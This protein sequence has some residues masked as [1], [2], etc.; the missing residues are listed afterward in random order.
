M[1]DQVNIEWEYSGKKDI[2]NGTGAYKEERFLGYLGSLI[3]PTLLIGLILT[4]KL[5]W[6]FVQIA[7]GL[8]LGFDIGGGMISNSLNSVKRFYH[9]PSKPSEGKSGKLVKNELIFSAIH[10]HPF[11]VGMVFHNYDWRYGLYWYVIFMASVLIV[12]NA[13]LYLKRPV[14]ML[15]VMVSILVNAYLITP[16]YG[17]QWF[18]PLLFLKIVYGHLV[19]EEPYRK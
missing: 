12:Y 2:I 10:L 16:V 3:I 4:D 9:S 11:V 1:K 18:I 6:N 14:A 7:V 19:R 5:E 15:T 17:L 8:I 13:P